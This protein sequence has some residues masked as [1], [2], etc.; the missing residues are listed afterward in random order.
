MVGTPS[1]DS[2]QSARVAVVEPGG[3]APGV[4]GPGAK[5][6]FKLD[7]GDTGGAL[8]I[9]EYEY[10]VGTL[11]APHRHAFLDEVSIVLE[12][13][14]G[15]RSGDREVVLRPGSYMV[16]PRGQVHA[17]WN[18]GSV[19]TRM[20]EIITPAGFEEGLHELSAMM[21]AGNAEPAAIAALGRRYQLE[22]A[23]PDW[24]P[25]V[26]ARYALNAPPS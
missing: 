19:P 17:M 13:E 16:K 3:G 12:G 21:L 25:E 6:R 14:V 22:F 18:A 8:S 10:A 4:L 5:V 15:F 20:I 2:A 7:G 23:K 9:M 11:V 1:Q 26:I 24:L